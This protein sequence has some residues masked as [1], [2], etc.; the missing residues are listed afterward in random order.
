MRLHLQYQCQKL[1]IVMGQFSI[2]GLAQSLFFGELALD[3]L[4]RPRS[5]PDSTQTQLFEMGKENWS[6]YGVRIIGLAQVSFDKI[7]SVNGYRCSCSCH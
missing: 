2:Q 1:Q 5:D 3:V 7:V 4:K 6:F